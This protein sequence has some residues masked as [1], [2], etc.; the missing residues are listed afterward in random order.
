MSSKLL[1]SML[2]LG[3]AAGGGTAWAQGTSGTGNTQM[4]SQSSG[5][6]STQSRQKGTQ[7]HQ[8]GRQMGQ[9]GQENTQSGTQMRRS[10]EM[11]QG[12]MKQGEMKRSGEKQGQGTMQSDRSPSKTSSQ[13]SAQNSAD[14][15]TR[16]QAQG[17]S[18]STGATSTRTQAQG[19]STSTGATSTRSEG[20]SE[21]G[22]LTSQQRTRITEVFKKENIR[23]EANANFSVSVGTEVPKTIHLHRLPREIVEVQPTWRAFEFVRVGDAILIVNPRTFQIVAVMPA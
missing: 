20:T 19:Q 10:G 8:P 4:Q 21:T 18:T 1:V 13:G 11:K 23:P 15:S 7:P 3:L 12:E 16:T 9:A 22:S 5:D 2:A 6:E 17:Q 14:Q